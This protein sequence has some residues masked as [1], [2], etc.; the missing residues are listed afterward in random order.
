MMSNSFTDKLIE[1][2]KN[3]T[4]KLSLP[5]RGKENVLKKK[6]HQ[7]LSYLLTSFLLSGSGFDWS[8]FKEFCDK[9]EILSTDI[10]LLN[11]YV[12]IAAQSPK[13]N[14]S[15][16]KKKQTIAPPTNENIDPSSSPISLNPEKNID[17]SS[18]S[19]V[20]TNGL[21]KNDDDDDTKKE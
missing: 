21:L 6:I 17:N 18:D 16:Q 3:P 1:R 12:V 9:D 8:R 13:K 10:E 5:S 11:A 14:S 19:S 2:M 20:V 15:N 7:R 4:K